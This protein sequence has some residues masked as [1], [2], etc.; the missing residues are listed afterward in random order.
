MS[1][2][3][4]AQRTRDYKIAFSTDEG[5]RV[6]NDIVTSCFV[7]DSTIGASP[8]ETAFNEGMRNAALRIMSMLHYSPE[9]FITLPERVEENV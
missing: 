5:R 9:D 8:Q 4:L 2:Q 3:K 1:S 6:L 7:L